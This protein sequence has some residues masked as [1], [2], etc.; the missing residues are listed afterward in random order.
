MNNSKVILGTLV[1]VLGALWGGWVSTESWNGIAYYYI[2]DKRQPAAVRKVIDFSH[3]EGSALQLASKKRLLA[4]AK[5]ISTDDGVGI[6]LG[7][8]ITRGSDGGKQFACYVY[9]RVQLV[10][11][12]EGL[13]VAGDKPTMTVESNC[14]IG[15]DINRI[16]AII[17][18]VNKVLKEKPGDLE[19][20]YLD[21]NPISIQFEHVV[22]QWP[23]EWSLG[24]V[25]LFNQMTPGQEVFIDHQQVREEAPQPI[26][27]VWKSPS[28]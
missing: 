28:L 2:G 22:D 23:Q 13:A 15:N 24:S 11:Y 19:L 20:K 16:S 21:G 7:H 26:K 14:L 4:D 18:P 3:L 6:E 5:I 9:N 1:T 25:K 10:F 12:A 27:M 17:I 8:F